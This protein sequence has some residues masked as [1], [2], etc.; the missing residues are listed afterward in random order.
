MKNEKQVFV[1]LKGII[2]G[3]QFAQISIFQLKNMFEI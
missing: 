3:R 1:F 2:R